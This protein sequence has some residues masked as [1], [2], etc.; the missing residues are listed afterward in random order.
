[1]R[2]GFLAP[3]N[4]EHVEVPPLNKA[5]PE[6]IEDLISILKRDTQ[7]GLLSLQKNRALTCL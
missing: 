1:M 7:C 2:T 3:E 6:M 4:V 5:N